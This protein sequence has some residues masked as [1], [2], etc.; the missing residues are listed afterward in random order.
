MLTRLEVHLS[1]PFPIDIAFNRI[2]QQKSI[3]AFCRELS[4]EGEFE[5]APRHR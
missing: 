5:Q 3:K 4:T 1:F 2:G